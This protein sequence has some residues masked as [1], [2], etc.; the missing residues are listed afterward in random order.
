[1]IQM[2]RRR[3]YFY[4]IY[5]EQPEFGWFLEEGR[6]GFVTQQNDG[7]WERQQMRHA[8][9]RKTVQYFEEGELRGGVTVTCN[10]HSTRSR[11]RQCLLR[12]LQCCGLRGT[13]R[14]RCTMCRCSGSPLALNKFPAL[15]MSLTI[16]AT[17]Q[18][19]MDAIADSNSFDISG[20]SVAILQGFLNS[21]VV[22][23]IDEAI[24]TL[25]IYC[26]HCSPQVA[27]DTLVANKWEVAQI[28]IDGFPNEDYKC[29][30]RIYTAEEPFPFYKWVNAP[31]FSKVCCA[32]LFFALFWFLF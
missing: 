31:F 7:E 14:S 25:R 18:N 26:P 11:H 20:T 19:P 10:T 2:K 30:I 17:P 5:A 28:H 8:G 29:A 15:P 22:V 21:T 12:L 6:V 13:R 24:E 27:E 3:I 23:S 16:A 32:V 9:M 1:M 4:L